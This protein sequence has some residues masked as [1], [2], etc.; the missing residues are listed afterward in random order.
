MLDRS[1]QLWLGVVLLVVGAMVLFGS[2]LSGGLPPVLLAVGVLVLAAGTLLVALGR[3][4]R[5]V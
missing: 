3:R 4:G 5:P 2:V 1:L